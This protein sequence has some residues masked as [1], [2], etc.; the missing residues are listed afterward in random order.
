MAKSNKR[1]ELVFLEGYSLFERD[2]ILNDRQGLAPGKH[3]DAKK[4]G[5]VFSVDNALILHQFNFNKH[6]KH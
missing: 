4:T 2:L 5:I 1:N 6:S 3:P